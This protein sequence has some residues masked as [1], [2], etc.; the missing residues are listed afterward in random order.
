M[1]SVKNDL[2]FTSEIGLSVNANNLLQY[3]STNT[4]I[5]LVKASIA[6]KYVIKFKSVHVHICNLIPWNNLTK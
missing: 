6:F 4:G 5:R 1:L 2:K 3:F